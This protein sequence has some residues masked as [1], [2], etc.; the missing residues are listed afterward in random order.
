MR[1]FSASEQRHHRRFSCAANDTLVATVNTAEWGERRRGLV[2]FSLGQRRAVRLR[3]PGGHHRMQFTYNSP[4]AI[5][6]WIDALHSVAR[7]PYAVQPR[8]LTGNRQ[9]RAAS[10]IDSTFRST[11]ART[12]G[13]TS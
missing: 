1:S 3:W 9:H 7:S 12:P 2:G 10:R 6:M 5:A 11:S 8:A 13:P 4:N